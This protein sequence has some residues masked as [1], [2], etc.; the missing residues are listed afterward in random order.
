[1]TTSKPL[2]QFHLFP[3][4]PTELRLAIYTTINNIPQNPIPA[5]SRSTRILKISF[6]PTLDRYISN[7]APPVLLSLCSESR[8]HI[9]KQHNTTHLLLGPSFFSAPQTNIPISFPTT[10]LYI[11]SLHPGVLTSSFANNVLY[12]LSTSPSRHQIASLALD[13]RVFTDFSDSGL[14]G[15]LAGMRGLRELCLV[16]EFGRKFE[17]VLGFLE[18]P[19]W[20]NDLKWYAGAAKE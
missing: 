17:G 16:L 19:E 11:S 13:L 2:Q 10:T 18:A 15:V 9:S 7:T 3:N 14:L 5:P 1:M 6:A 8:N 20:R 12:H 4:L